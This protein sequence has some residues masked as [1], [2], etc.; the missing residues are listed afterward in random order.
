MTTYKATD[1]GSR[2][3]QFSRD[4]PERRAFSQALAHDFQIIVRP[5]TL[6]VC[7]GQ[8]DLGRFSQ[9]YHCPP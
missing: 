9:P 7:H 5:L 4:R 2:G 1:G 6:N 3:I 8:A